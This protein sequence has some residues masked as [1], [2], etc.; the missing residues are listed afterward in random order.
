MATIDPLTIPLPQNLFD[1]GRQLFEGC[2][3]LVEIPV[4]VIRAADP[5][6]DVAEA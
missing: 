6:Q 3:F 2:G 5:G 4:P 1:F